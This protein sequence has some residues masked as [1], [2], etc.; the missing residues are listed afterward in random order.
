MRE[1]VMSEATPTPWT[2]EPCD[3]PAGTALVD[4][5]GECILAGY[6]YNDGPGEWRATVERIARAVNSHD[7][8]VETAEAIAA[9]W[10]QG[11]NSGQQYAHAVRLAQETLLDV[12]RGVK[13]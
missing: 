3:D 10:N 8:L 7:A 12:A 11:R 2:V 13:P 9:S 1:D 5:R 6:E 4:A